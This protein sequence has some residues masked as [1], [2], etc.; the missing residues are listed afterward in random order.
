[1]MYDVDDLCSDYAFDYYH[2]TCIDDVQIEFVAIDGN[3]A[4]L[5][6]FSCFNS[7]CCELMNNALTTKFN[8]IVSHCLH[9]RSSM[10]EV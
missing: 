3:K 2:R 1:M 5:D 9:W 10:I 6:L 8:H 4:N 7:D